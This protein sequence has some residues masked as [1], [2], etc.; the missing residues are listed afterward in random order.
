[1]RISA[2]VCSRYFKRYIER[3]VFAEAEKPNFIPL[4][5]YILLLINIY[6]YI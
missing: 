4:R 2:K 6:R 3:E 1:M 5:G